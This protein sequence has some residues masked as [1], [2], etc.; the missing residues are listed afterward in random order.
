MKTAIVY[1]SEH[2]GNTKKLLDAIA[3]EHEVTLIDVTKQPPADLSGYDRIG[4]ASGIYYSSFAGQLL[5]YA[6]EHL[7]EQKEVF[8]IYTHGAPK[9]LSAAWPRAI[10]QKRKSAPPFRSTQASESGFRFFPPARP[11]VSGRLSVRS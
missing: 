8:Y 4:L 5:D 11:P 2:H 6:R 10:R 9:G 3:A 7:P 1:Y